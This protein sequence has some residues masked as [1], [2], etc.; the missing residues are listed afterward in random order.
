[1]TNQNVTA[2]PTPVHAVPRRTFTE[3]LML[4]LHDADKQQLVLVARALL[5]VVAGYAPF[6][7]LNDALAPFTLGLAFADDLAIP[8]GVLAAIK[9]FFEVKKYQS[10]SYRPRR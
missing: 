9:I 2:E 1:M 10:P 3:A 4:W 5:L 7:A 8:V 6:A